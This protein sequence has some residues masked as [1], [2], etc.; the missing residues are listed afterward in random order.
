MKVLV[1][2]SSATLISVFI[3]LAGIVNAT[4]RRNA[5]NKHQ[6]RN[7]EALR[8]RQLDTSTS[9]S[10]PPFI[11]FTGLAASPSTQPTGDAGEIRIMQDTVSPTPR[12]SPQSDTSGYAHRSSAEVNTT[13]IS[14][15]AAQSGAGGTGHHASSPTAYADSTSPDQKANVYGIAVGVVLAVLIMAGLGVWWCVW[16]RRE[17]DR[18]RMREEERGEEM[19]MEERGRNDGPGSSVVWDRT[20]LDRGKRVSEGRDGDGKVW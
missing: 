6:S 3:L 7:Q 10:V 4:E 16:W 18:A 14:S 11:T 20:G 13:A 1:L 8:N 17:R 5:N 15:D 2:L 12:V 9:L 19:S